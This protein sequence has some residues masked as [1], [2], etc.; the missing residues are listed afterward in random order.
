VKTFGRIVPKGG[1]GL[2]EKNVRVL[3]TKNA[4]IAAV[5][6]P[7]LQTRQVARGNCAALDRRLIRLVQGDATCRMLMTMPGIG[8]ITAVDYAAALEKADNFKVL[9][10]LYSSSNPDVPA[11]TW[12]RSIPVASLR[13][14]QTARETVG[15]RFSNAHHAAVPCRP[16]RLAYTAT[17]KRSLTSSLRLDNEAN[18]NRSMGT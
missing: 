11:G 10:F 1:G 13:L 8:P 15:G 4:A 3:I 17:S 6:M 2:F 5:T 7:L 12:A 16:R 18:R 14:I 9:Y